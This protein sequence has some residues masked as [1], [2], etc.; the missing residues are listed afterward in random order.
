M[1]RSWGGGGQLREAGLEMSDREEDPGLQ[2]GL[3]ERLNWSLSCSVPLLLG[4]AI[5]L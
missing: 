4:L 5:T 1:G 2:R 3:D